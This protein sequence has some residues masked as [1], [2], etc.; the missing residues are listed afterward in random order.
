LFSGVTNELESTTTRRRRL[1]FYYHSNFYSS[2][3]Y[4]SSYYSSS[5]YSSSY[6]SS[7]NDDDNA[8]LT[9]SYDNYWFIGPELLSSFYPSGKNYAYNGYYYD[10]STFGFPWRIDVGYNKWWPKEIG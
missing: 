4:S 8:Y 7:S 10:H 5:Y 1:T 2:Y 6:Y 3:Y 9:Q